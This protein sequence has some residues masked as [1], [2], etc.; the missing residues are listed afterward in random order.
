MLQDSATDQQLH[1]RCN[2]TPAHPSMPQ[3]EPS[4]ATDPL[5]FQACRIVHG[6]T[7]SDVSM[8]YLSSLFSLNPW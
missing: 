7:S 1:A 3:L 5:S 4:F 2:G 8:G 6:S